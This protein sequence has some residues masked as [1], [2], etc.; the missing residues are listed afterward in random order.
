[1][2]WLEDHSRLFV[3]VF[4]VLG[5]LLAWSTSPPSM[6]WS[7]LSSLEDADVTNFPRPFFSSQSLYLLAPSHWTAPQTFQSPLS[8][9]FIIR[10]SFLQIAIHSL[11]CVIIIKLLATQCCQTCFQVPITKLNTEWRKCNQCDSF[12]VIIKL[13]LFVQNCFQVPTALDS[14]RHDLCTSALFNHLKC[15][16][17]LFIILTAVMCQ[18]RKE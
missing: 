7:S 12:C 6:R 16:C 18:L 11:C 10:T 4:V 15:I 1:M 5:G 8:Q 2:S 14:R 13:A 3:V 17:W 9:L